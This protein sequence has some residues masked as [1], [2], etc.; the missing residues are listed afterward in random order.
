M[1]RNFFV[2]TAIALAVAMPQAAFA[3]DAEAEFV[4][5][6]EDVWQ[7]ALDGSPW[8]SE[9]VGD[10]RNDGSLGDPSIE[11][12]DEG[13]AQTREFQARLQA[14]DVD[15]LPENL[16]IDYALLA[17]SFNDQLEAAEHDHSRYITFTNRG[18]PQSAIASLPY[19]SPLF[20]AADYDSY[21]TRLESF[22]E[23]IQ[24]F[25]DRSE[26]AIER[27]LTQPCEPMQGYEN[28]ISGFITETP[29]DSVWWQAFDER[30]ATI[31]ETDWAGIEDRGRTAITEGAFAG[32]QAFRDYYVQDFAPACRA[33]EAPGIGGTPGGE[34]YYAYRVRSFTTTDMTPQQVHDLGLSEVARIRAEMEA[35]AAEAGFDTREAFIEHLR[36]DPQYYP[37]DEE[38]YLEYTRALA[39]EIDGWMPRLF[40]RLP[41]L[42]YS[43]EPIPAAVAPGNTTAYYER[44]SMAT[45]QP[46]IYRLNLTELDQRPLW[47]L[48][49]LGV[50]EA[51]PGHHHQIALQ[52]ELDMHP[53][54]ANG[55]F[56]TAFVEGW[57]LYSERL[58][59]EMGL[60]DTPAKEMGRLSYEMWRA[61]RLVVDTGIHA[62]GWTRD[63]AVA[64][65]LDNTA[66]SEGNINAEVNRY[67][68]WPGQAVA[69]KIGELKIRELRTRAEEALGADFDLRDFHDTVLENGAVPLNVLEAHVDAWIASELAE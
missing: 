56:F 50:H 38:S 37:E 4:E 69:Y 34:A 28:S 51:V 63:E 44:G 26:G 18:G 24:A 61:T 57:G 1:T 3:Q 22:P 20:T 68:T 9:G 7:N 65:M 42:P 47:E 58:G 48:P 46:G 33:D 15:M 5:L 67:I 12:Y 39:K 14:I 40:G 62:M 36:T 59:I 64:Y 6:R 52:Q 8:L 30:P 10:R 19:S 31:S 35:V 27:G 66:L 55:S 16:R 25:I 21:L 17:R 43:V 11:G 54:R 23:Y 60:Y 53:L 2:T 41:R 29:E 49:A 45:G 13:I 32:L